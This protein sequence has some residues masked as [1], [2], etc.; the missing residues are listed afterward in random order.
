MQQ[1][2]LILAKRIVTYVGLVMDF[3]IF[4]STYLFNFVD[5]E[6]IHIELDNLQE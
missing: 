6:L 2:D 4:N 3:M 5:N 1:N